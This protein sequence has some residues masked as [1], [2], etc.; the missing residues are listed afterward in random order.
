MGNGSNMV[1]QIYSSHLRST[2]SVGMALLSKPSHSNELG[3]LSSLSPWLGKH[4]TILTVLQ[5]ELEFKMHGQGHLHGD[6][7]AIWFTA[8]RAETGKVFGFRDNFNGLGI[9]IDTYKNGRTGT[10]FPY[11]MGMLGNSS[12]SYDKDMDG[13]DQELAGC[14]VSLLHLQTWP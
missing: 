10:V 4:C 7:M 5:V 12:V 9:F 8:E 1:A 13:Q 3:G 14:S 2:S 11:V 6:G